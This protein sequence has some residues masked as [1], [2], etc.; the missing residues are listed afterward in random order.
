MT[1]LAPWIEQ[2]QYFTSDLWEQFWSD[3]TRRTRQSWQDF[4][5]RL[6]LEA[7]D[8]YLG[9]RGYERS[10]ARADA[11]NGFYE[12]DVVTVLA[13]EAR[14]RRRQ[15]GR[16]GHLSGQYAGRRRERRPA[17]RAS[18]AGGIP[19]AGH[20][21]ALGS[22]KI[23]RVLPRSAGLW[24]TLRTTNVIARCCVEVRR[25]TRPMVC[26]VNVQSVERIICSIVNRFNLGWGLR[27]LRQFTHVACHPLPVARSCSSD[28]EGVFL[29]AYNHRSRVTRGCD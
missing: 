9:V 11:R 3:L 19:A 1:T 24:G 2:W 23:G 25:R 28:R 12:R 7:R 6:S 8:R 20:A 26:V 22:A 13:P 16:P 29:C 27:T 4:L 21:A 5:G 10:P 15:G 14:P 18:M 17:L